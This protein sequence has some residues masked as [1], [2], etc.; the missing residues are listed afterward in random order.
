M[1][2]DIFNGIERIRESGFG[3]DCEEEKGAG[4]VHSRAVGCQ[5][6]PT[7]WNNEG[8]RDTDLSALSS[9]PLFLPTHASLSNYI[10]KTERSQSVY[11]GLSYIKQGLN[12]FG[13]LGGLAK[14]LLA[15]IQY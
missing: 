11:L 6:L 10:S 4:T 13:I 9:G 12:A 14:N 2:V 7:H 5:C 1:C 15:G 3:I 8:G